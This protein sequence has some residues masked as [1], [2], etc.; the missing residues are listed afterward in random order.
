MIS[1]F[2]R[3]VEL[4]AICAHPAGLSC[5]KTDDERVGLHVLGYNR[6]CS[7]ERELSDCSAGDD[8]TIRAECCPA[9][10]EGWPVL[11]LT[12]HKTSGIYDVC[13]HH[14]RSAEDALLESDA[15]IYRDIVLNLASISDKNSMSY[16]DVLPKR[17]AFANSR[18]RTDMYEVPD[19][20]T[21]AN[22]GALIYDGARVRKVVHLIISRRGG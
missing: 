20:A 13:K 21:V 22:L 4:F 10:N 18:S 6:A 1:P 7:N 12:R 9:A 16:K 14:R 11:V 19:A 15:V 5:G 2:E 17:D 3:E 8:R